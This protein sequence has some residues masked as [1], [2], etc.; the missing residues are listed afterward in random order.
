[1]RVSF[2]AANDGFDGRAAAQSALDDPE[3]AA[4][5]TGNEDAV[6][7]GRAVASSIAQA[8]SFSV[9]SMTAASV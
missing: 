4:V 9:A 5:L 7:I 6:R 3:D 8:V 2:H 1:M